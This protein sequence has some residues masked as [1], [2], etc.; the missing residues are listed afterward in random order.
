M[1]ANQLWLMCI[2]IFIQL[3][4]SSFHGGTF[5]ALAGKNSVVLVSD[6]RFSSPAT[7]QT[8]LGSHPRII[9]RVGSRS[10]VGFY[11]LDAHARILM[12]SVQEKLFN[13]RDS[14]F[15]PKSLTRVVSD[16]LYEKEFYVSPI[17][18]GLDDNNAPFLCTMDGL[19]A[20][21]RS[22]KFAVSGTA[23]QGL[24]AL[25]ESLYIPQLETSELVKLAERCFNL[26]M[27]RD[28]KSG[29][30]YRILTLTKDALYSKIVKKLDM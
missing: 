16:T 4:V 11:G 13:M 6:S 12:N 27:Q 7:G 25:C 3:V 5:L 22:D 21:T 30:N 29:S 2:I 9:F 18:V 17:V 23:D 8:L 15:G 24:L 26:A 14:D 1:L 19:G 28:V 20:Q 10:L